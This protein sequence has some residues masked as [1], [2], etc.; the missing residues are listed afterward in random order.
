MG[1]S[2]ADTSKSL[3]IEGRAPKKVITKLSIQL[4][5]ERTVN[6]YST[7]K[8]FLVHYSQNYND[9]SCEL[10]VAVV[11]LLIVQLIVKLSIRFGVP[12]I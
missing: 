9:N 11:R 3:Y 5:L 10:V 8:T 4:T 1:H 12:K 7:S 2:E 6:R